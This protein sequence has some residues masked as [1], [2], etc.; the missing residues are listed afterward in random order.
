MFAP[1]SLKS[2]FKLTGMAVLFVMIFGMNTGCG[3]QSG[4]SE[5][6]DYYTKLGV[7]LPDDLERIVFRMLDKHQYQIVRRTTSMEQIYYETEWRVRYPFEDEIKLGV[8]SA[9]SRIIITARPRDFGG[10]GTILVYRV[11]FYAENEVRFSDTS[12]YTRIPIS[13]MAKRYFRRIANDI[14]TEMNIEYHKGR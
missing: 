4:P 3:H 6:K 11:K 14:K 7:S 12:G 13:D 2:A 8:A 9:R 1:L 10:T 5:Y